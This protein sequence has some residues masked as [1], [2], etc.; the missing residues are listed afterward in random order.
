MFEK[1]KQNA[2][3]VK[4]AADKARRAKD[5]VK[6]FRD[7]NSNRHGECE[8]VGCGRKCRTGYNTCGKSACQK[9]VARQ[10]AD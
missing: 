2:Q 10:Y 3:K 8:A 7:R 9:D 1:S 6:D 4:D 5:G